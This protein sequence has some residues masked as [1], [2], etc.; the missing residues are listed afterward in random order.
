MLYL[1]PPDS[2]L[3]QSS[4]LLGHG[5]RSLR[6]SQIIPDH[7]PISNKWPDPSEVISDL[8]MVTEHAGLGC[9]AQPFQ[10]IEVAS[11]LFSCLRDLG[12]SQ[13]SSNLHSLPMG[14]KC[15]S[16]PQLAPVEEQFNF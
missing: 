13:H 11:L 12:I 9:A 10:M 7:F 16:G 15:K 5:R 4:G 1:P 6:L 8:Q 14:G 2:G 3:Q